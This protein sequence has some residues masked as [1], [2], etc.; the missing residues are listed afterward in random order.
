MKYLMVFLK[1]EMWCFHEPE[2]LN[3]TPKILTGVF[4]EAG[5]IEVLLKVANVSH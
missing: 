5:L 2:E 4:G 3:H 1:D